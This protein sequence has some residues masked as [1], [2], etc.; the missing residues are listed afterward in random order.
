[1]YI[2][3]NKHH[4]TV[5]LIQTDEN[6]YVMSNDVIMMRKRMCSLVI[7]WRARCKAAQRKDGRV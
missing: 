4:A 6:T 5:S 3:G 1:M 7:K 2:K